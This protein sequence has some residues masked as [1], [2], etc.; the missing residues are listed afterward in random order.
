MRATVSSAASIPAFM[1][2]GLELATKMV[3]E[4][5]GGTPSEAVVVGKTDGA[6]RV[7]DFPIGEIKRLAGIEVSLNE[8][9]RILGLLGFSI[10]GTGPVIKVAVPSWRA[11]VAGKADIVEEIVRIVGVDRVPLTPFDRGDAP[12]KPI[13]T[14]IQLRTRRA[15]RALAARGMT[16]AVTWSFVSHPHAELF[17]GGQ[18]TLVL[19]NPIAADLSD[20]RPSLI[21]GLVVAAQQNADRGFDDVALFEVGQIFKGDRPEDQSI[22]A[23]GIRR[24]LASSKGIGRHWSGTFTR[25]RVRRQERR[26]RGAR[27]RRRADELAADRARAARPGCIPGARRRSRSGRRTSSAISANCIRARCEALGADKPLDAFEVILD[28]IPEPRAKPTRAKPLLEL[29]PFQPVSR[30]FAF[31]VDRTVK[32]ADIVRA[33][34]GADRKLITAV[35]VF[36]VYE[37]K[38]IDDAKKSIAIAVTLAAARK[39][40]DRSGDRRRGRE[41]RCR[42]DEEDRRHVARMTIADLLPADIS[43]SR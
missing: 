11:D 38:G 30:D 2:P 1:V 35:N 25:R 6:D 42:G 24:A 23:S 3:M 36:D 34:Q 14:P 16:E 43:A 33:A 21:P 8:I 28:R 39:D 7:I 17:G 32:A 40:A 22:A 29:S 37:G 26:A 13:L 10:A 5:C 18:P 19:A 15:K 31:I 20:M 12:R 9:R 4:L 27:R 41:D